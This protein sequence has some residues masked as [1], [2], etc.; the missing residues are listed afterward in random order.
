MTFVVPLAFAFSTPAWGMEDCGIVPGDRWWFAAGG[1]LICDTDGR[2][3]DAATCE[4]P[5]GVTLSLRVEEVAPPTVLTIV[6][7]CGPRE[8]GFVA[9]EGAQA[10]DY[11]KAKG[12]RDVEIVVAPCA[13]T[14]SITAKV[15]P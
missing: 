9:R 1:L 6:P 3:V 5:I 2:V 7:P 8:D 11:L 10:L 4:I 13:A 15:K 14:P 12:V